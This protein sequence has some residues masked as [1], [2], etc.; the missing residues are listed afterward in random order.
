L[1][2]AGTSVVANDDGRPSL[3]RL[4]AIVEQVAELHRSGMEVI[5]VSSGATGMGKRLMRKQGRMTM[6]MAE[7]ASSNDLSE[8]AEGVNDIQLRSESSSFLDEGV[9]SNGGDSALSEKDSKRTFNSAC[10]AGGQ[11]EMMSLYNSLFTQMDISAAQILLTEGD[12]R[13]ESHLTSLM[14]SIERL[15][16][17]GIIPIINENDAISANRGSSPNDMFS[18]NDSL[19]A[20]CAR[21][22]SCDLCILLTDVDGVF[23]RPP[24]ENGAKL[25][26]FYSQNQTVGIGEKSKHGRG[27]MDSKINAAQFA[28]SPGSQCRACVVLSG[29]DLDSIR[30]IAS[31]DYD[32]SEGAGPK[33]T[34][35]ATPE[36]ELEKQAIKDC[37]DNAI[38]ESVSDAARKMATSS[39]DQA[40][41]IQNLPHAERKAILYAVADALEAEKETLLA[42]NKI[43]L[44]NA[45]KNKTDLQLVRRLK[46][47]DGKLA[48]LSAGIRQIADQPDPLGVVKAKR[49]L[50]NGLELSQIT[51]PIGVLMIIFESRPDSMPQIAALALA[52]GNGLLL[53]GGKEASASNEAIHK[54]IGDAIEK[55]SGGKI[56]RDIIAL[57]TSRGQVADMLKLDDVVDLV[58]PRG[59]NALVSYIKANTRIPVLGH[60]DG[61]CH[62]YVDKSAKDASLV[63]K[64]VVDAKTDYP[65]ACNAMETLLL[66]KDT[67]KNTSEGNLAMSVLMSLRM[68]GVKCL[69]GPKAMK[70]G[71]CDIEAKER[72]CEYGDLTCQIEIVEDMEEAINWIHAYGSGHTEAIVCDESS[73]AGEEFLKRVDA[74]CVFKNASTRFADGYRFGLGAEVGISTGRIHARGP[75]G[76]E[77]LLT[78][79]WQLRSDDGIN[80]ASEYGGDSPTKVYTHKD[81]M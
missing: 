45:E 75:V 1:I 20:L 76:V 52:S 29:A 27:G 30:S 6:T 12:F 71:L 13:D 60:A 35:F 53:K 58:I 11:F 40:R 63:T 46:L 37:E 72:K 28:V 9:L 43:D 69:G 68:A 81:L 8:L 79:K 62:V 22:F 78:V 55:G 36:S 16:S 57:V 10:A 38:N 15:L 26:P 59:S 25:L 47:T 42:A 5:I 31:K 39:R 51:V 50:A 65:S 32:D 19:A 56:T 64:L 49:E 67:L 2:K 34:L 70:S 41:K 14:Y 61:V 77:G 4:G 66:H 3:T 48:T 73:D 74:A 17:V 18:D 7:V 24:N 44:E 23:D 21:S 54:V 80:C 33:G